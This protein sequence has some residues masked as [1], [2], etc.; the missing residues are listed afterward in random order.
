M[1][2]QTG[3]DWVAELLGLLTREY[4]AVEI[5]SEQLSIAEVKV[6]TAEIDKAQVK[7]QLGTEV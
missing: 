7:S 2:T 1:D 5:D 6:K 4:V 3:R